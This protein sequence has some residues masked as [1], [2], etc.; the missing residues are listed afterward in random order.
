MRAHDAYLAPF[1]KLS[2]AEFN[3]PV[4]QRNYS[5]DTENCQQLF[6]DIE[7]I[8]NTQK[9]HFIGSIVYVSIGTATEPYYN[10]IDGQQRITSVMLFLKALYD[11]T[12]DDKFKK[13]IRNGFLVNTGFDDQPKMKL[14]QV[15]SDQSIFEKIIM[16]QDFL[17][18]AF[19]TTEKNSNVY[20]NYSFFKDRIEQSSST[21]QSLYSA[22]FKLEIIDVC[23]TTEDPQEV[24]ESM[25]STGKSLTNTDLLRNYLL[26]D[27]K[28]NQQTKLYKNYWLQIEKNVG[29]KLMEQYMVH[30]LIMK[31]KSDSINIHRRSGKINRNTLYDCYKIYFPP[32][33][34]ANNGT[35]RLLADM[36]HFSTIYKKIVNNNALTELDK[37]INE[38]IYELSAEQVAIFLMHL[39]Y[40][41]EQGIISD[42]D[43]LLAVRACISYVLRVRIFKG[44]IANQFFALAIQYF[45]RGDSSV[46]FITRVWDALNSGQGSYRFPKDREFQNAFETKDMFL[47]FKP[48]MLRYIL[49]KFE[50]KVS[51]EVVEPDNVT[52]EH[53]LPQEPEKWQEHLLKIHDNSYREY[54]HRIGNLTLTKLNSEA[55]NNPFEKKKTIYAKSGYMITRE[56]ANYSDWTSNEIRK[57]SNAMA[58]EALKIW[59]LPEKYN[60]DISASAW[61]IMDDQIEEV[62]NQLSEMIKEYDPYIFEELKKNWINFIKDKKIIL[63]VVPCQSYMWIT[64]NTNLEKLTPND[65]LEDI[66]EKGHWGI[67][68]C[69]M[70]L[71]NNEDIWTVLSYI[72][73]ILDNK[74]M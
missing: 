58:L 32:E 71:T 17:E 39:L 53:I 1:L 18:D 64:L 42:E 22:I 31:R 50:R 45:D 67:G 6:S 8:T 4:Y 68:K 52:I 29:S 70:K 2:D 34:K 60:Q 56:I 46:P 73:Q 12:D 54:T 65:S 57:R 19:S 66:T 27:L 37:A 7:T 35:E 59:P 21:L 13:Q 63:S 40:V 44:S 9:D 38:L 55:S 74:K 48:Q 41:Q 5:W 15:E 43:M 3:I 26:M 11:S 20:R 28:G 62:Y 72:E 10:I 16:Q 24:F 30:Y 51:K 25:N 33:N 14:K 47:E 36:Y 23:L 69:R 49:Y 61:R